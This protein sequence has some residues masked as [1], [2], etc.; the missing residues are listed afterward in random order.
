MDADKRL[1]FV[2][3]GPSGVGKGTLLDMVCKA[4]SCLKRSVSCTTRLPREKDID[5]VD[6]YFLS[7]KEFLKRA[8]AGEFLE[9]A[10]VHDNCYGTLTSEVSS[11]KQ[12]GYD[13]ILE[14]DVQGA[15][16]VKKA[17]PQ[18]ITIFVMP[19]SMEELA[20][21]LAKRGTEDE[22]SIKMRLENARKEILKKDDFD[23][24]MTNDDIEKALEELQKIINKKRGC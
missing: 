1:L 6:Y 20:A 5:G 23:Y 24:I 8:Q 22:A 17:I 21:R 2:I 11:L 4:T 12:K 15:A 18:A 19:P 13:V 7:K 16:S 3:S 14:I 10:Q 9:W